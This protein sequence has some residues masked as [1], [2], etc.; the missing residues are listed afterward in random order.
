M[1]CSSQLVDPGPNTWAFVRLLL[2]NAVTGFKA[3]W[4]STKGLMDMK[5]EGAQLLQQHHPDPNPDLL[6]PLHVAQSDLSLIGHP[7]YIRAIAVAL[8]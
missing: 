8:A 7:R 6:L 3:P 1:L 2:N 4:S 5:F